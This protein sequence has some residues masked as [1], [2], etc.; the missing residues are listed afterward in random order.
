MKIISDH[1]FHILRM[2]LIALQR[3]SKRKIS[4][5]LSRE[6]FEHERLSVRFVEF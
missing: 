3:A 6:A 5:T 4:F 1:L 2:N